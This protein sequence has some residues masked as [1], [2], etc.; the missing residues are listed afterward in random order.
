MEEII[1]HRMEDV[2]TSV[3]RQTR[4]LCKELDSKIEE[5]QLGL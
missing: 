1:K 3:D 5:I 4:G 2:L